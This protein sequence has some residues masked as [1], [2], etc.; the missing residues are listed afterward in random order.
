MEVFGFITPLIYWILILLWSYVLAFYLRKIFFK[1]STDK[2]LKILLVILALDAFRTLFES[3]YFGAW[4]TSLS[5]LIPISV[6][7]YLAQPQVVFVPKIINLITS[8]LILVIII[9]KWLP[10]ETERIEIYNTILKQQTLELQKYHNATIN[11]PHPIMIHAED[12]EVIMIN[13][14]WTESTGYQMEEINTIS[15]WTRNAY[16]EKAGDIKAYIDKLYQIGDVI[17]ESEYKVK[18]K[19]GE[20]RIW[21][22]NSAPLE[23]MTDGRRMVISTAVDITE[24]KK[25]ELELEEQR[26]N[27]E[28][29]VKERTSELDK[30]NKELLEKN[31][32]LE[33]FNQIFVDREIRIKELK[34]EIEKLKK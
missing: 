19:T 1:L 28:E 31:T 18:T 17:K 20:E 11:S 6:Y 21:D 10:Q 29:L 26:K 23:A 32:E 2:F 7:N 14:A 16:G 33:N 3:L 22:F 27:L 4:F 8:V 13:K 34:N 5:H 12:G 9:R 25:V 30:T 24:L 15:K